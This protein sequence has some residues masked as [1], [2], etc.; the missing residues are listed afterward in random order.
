MRVRASLLVVVA[1]LT[2]ATGTVAAADNAAPMAD[3]GV[4]QTVAVNSTA[5]LDASGSVD[6]DGNITTVSWT[7]ETPDGGTTSPDCA[8]C[9]RTEFDADTVGQY[10]VTLT[11]T[12]DDGATRSDTLYVTVTNES[13]PD[14][15]LSGPSS[16]APNTG[17][18][19][20]ASV[21]KDD[22][23]LQTLTWLVDGSV[24]ERMTL[25]GS[26]ATVSFVRSFDSAASVRVVVY[27][28]LG[29]R[30]SA[31]RRVSIDS[32]GG[33]GGGGGGG[34]T[35]SGCYAIWCGS[36][37]DMRYTTDGET[38]IADTNNDDKIQTYENGVL[39]EIDTDANAVSETGGGGFTIDG[40]VEA[41]S[42]KY[43]TKEEG[44]N[45][46][47]GDSVDGP[48]GDGSDG[49]GN[50]NHDGDADD[51]G[52]SH[53]GSSS[54][55]NGGSNDGGSSNDDGGS[56]D[57]GS[58]SDDGDSNDGG[59]SSDDGD[60]ND[61]GGFLDGIFG[62]GGDSSDD[63]DSGGGDDS[64]DSDG[65]FFDGIFGGGGDSSDSDDGSDS[66]GGG[67]FGGLGF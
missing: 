37:A 54:I 14:V 17:A 15:S 39:T 59:S 20:T 45:V 25:N 32:G 51:D 36:D 67:F 58:S 49:G 38:T 18:T 10:T 28:T 46:N 19:F 53:D 44:R 11:V 60:S 24:A 31:T 35:S 56:N 8:D 7:V 6:P 41:V 42:D 40:G 4:D 62:G 30:G 21:S 57:G 9:R 52:G 26:S 63:S 29:D 47:K 55:D 23:S 65:G 13:G 1:V 64:S 2:A 66:G 43:K 16:T 34:T 22:A 5:Y 3:A 33:G 48:I 27:D 12:D 61:G 50:S